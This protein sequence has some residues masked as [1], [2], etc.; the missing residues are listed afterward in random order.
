M[1]TLKTLVKTAGQ[2]SSAVLAVRT[3][4]MGTRGAVLG[5][6]GYRQTPNCLEIM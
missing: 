4:P 1:K 3:V 2:K 5:D 6:R